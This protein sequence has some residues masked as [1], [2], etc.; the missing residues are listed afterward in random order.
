M[1]TEPV[2]PTC[3]KSIFAPNFFFKSAK[4]KKR[5]GENSLK[6]CSEKKMNMLGELKHVQ[7]AQ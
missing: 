4:I 1:F 3:W 5:K 2:R 6:T 7:H